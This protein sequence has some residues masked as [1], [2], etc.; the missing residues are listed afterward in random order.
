MCHVFYNCDNN[1]NNK[2]WQGWGI[3]VVLR[4]NITYVWIYPWLP[5]P[6]GKLW[7][8][9]PCATV[10]YVTPRIN[11]KKHIK[12]QNVVYRIVICVSDW[13]AGRAEKRIHPFFTRFNSTEQR[14]QNDPGANVFFAFFQVRFSRTPKVVSSEAIA[15]MDLSAIR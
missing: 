8:T 6:S 11:N 7:Q 5:R 1:N 4:Y 14:C 3:P 15:E 13:A 9:D 12:Y 2:K 10:D